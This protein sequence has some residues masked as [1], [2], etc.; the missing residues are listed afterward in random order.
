MRLPKFEHFEPKTLET[1][2]SMLSEKGEGAYVMAGGTDIVVKMTHGRLKPNT[3]IGLQRIEGLNEIRFSAKEGLTIGATARLAQ[4]ASHPDIL[5]HYPAF[6]YAAQV[7]ANVQVRNMGT[8]AGNLCNA[9]PSAE[10]APPLMA[11]KAEVTVVGLKGERRIPLDQFFIGPGLTVMEH[12]EIMISIF[13]PSPEPKSG[14]SYKRI[15]ARCGVDIAAVCAGAMVVLDGKVCKEAR[16]VLGAVAP[17]PMR[18]IKAEGLI[19]GQEWTHELIEKAAA[20]AAEESK[21]ISDVRANADY[22]KKMV[23]VLTLRALEEAHERAME[24]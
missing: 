15:S 6:A 21:P 3:I 2:L 24:R 17:V 12:G 18:A 4:V 9:A 13:V 7:M 10:N 19:T 1:A 8:V 5:K 22:R 20:Q 23:A 14:A 16:I 11:M